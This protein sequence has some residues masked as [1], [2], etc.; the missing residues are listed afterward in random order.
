[1]IQQA[2]YAP[3][4]GALQERS[5]AGERAFQ[6]HAQHSLT[7]GQAVGGL[8]EDDGLCAVDNLGRDFLAPMRGQALYEHGV[9]SGPRQQRRVDV[10]GRERAQ[11]L[12]A[13]L[14]K[15]KY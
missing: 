4:S 9:P 5:G 15:A 11:T 2:I 14:N 1:M 13:R 6:Q 3:V 10:V 12:C 8:G 7:G